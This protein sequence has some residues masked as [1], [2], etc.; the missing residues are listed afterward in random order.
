[1]YRPPGSDTVF[2]DEFQNILPPLPLHVKTWVITGDFSLHIDANPHRTKVFHDILS[3]FD[4]QQLVSFP[5]H[6]HG[7][8]LDLLVASSACAFRYLFQSDRMSDHFT[9]IDVMSLPSPYTY[10]SKDYTIP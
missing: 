8:T 6:A 9:V 10:L 3:S 2:F 1:M 5:T 7:H 4:L